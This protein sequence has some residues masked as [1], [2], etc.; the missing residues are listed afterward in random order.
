MRPA[1]QSVLPGLRAAGQGSRVGAVHR[2][3]RLLCRDPVIGT[4]RTLLQVY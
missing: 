1:E 4:P 3:L 2:S